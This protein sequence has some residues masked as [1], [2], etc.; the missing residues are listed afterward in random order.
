MLVC[1][2]LDYRVSVKC[3]KRW[4]WSVHGRRRFCFVKAAPTTGELM[5]FLFFRKNIDF[6][7]NFFSYRKIKCSSFQLLIFL[8][9]FLRKSQLWKFKRNQSIQIILP[10]FAVNKSI[11]NNQLYPAR[12]TTVFCF[13]AADRR[14]AGT[15]RPFGHKW[16]FSL[17]LV[18]RWAKAVGCFVGDMI[19]D[20]DED[21]QEQNKNKQR[22]Y[23]C[24]NGP[25]PLLHGAPEWGRDR[26][27]MQLWPRR[28]NLNCPNILF[29]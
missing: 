9:L 15:A 29:F 4:V 10:D 20:H 22:A 14:C 16:S 1:L 27:V 18:C 6:D 12:C 24:T 17:S 23:D 26:W 19:A 21:T 28:I 25:P 7:Q 2:E 8:F 13:A 3:V 11:N 5:T